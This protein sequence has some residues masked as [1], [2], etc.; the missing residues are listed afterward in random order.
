MFL[1]LCGFSGQ[2][3]SV[4]DINAN[5]AGRPA[6]RI[7]GEISFSRVF[8]T[9]YRRHCLFDV[10]T[11]AGFSRVAAEKGKKLWQEF[12]PLE[13]VTTRLHFH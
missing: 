10:F 9:C 11:V 2:P 4:G 12:P 5:W 1:K 3:L 8:M 7:F 13:E 6:V